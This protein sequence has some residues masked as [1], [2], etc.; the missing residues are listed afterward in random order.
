MS[1]CAN[2]KRLKEAIR[3]ITESSG[4]A[5]YWVDVLEPR[6][7]LPLLLRVYIDK[8]GGVGYAECEAV[9]RLV[10]EYLDAN[11]ERLSPL[12]DGEYF[13]EVSSPGIERPLFTPEHYMGAHGK[14]ALVFTKGRKKYEGTLLA[15]DAD[16]VTVVSDD[17]T[18]RVIAM[19]DIKKG[20]L[21]YESQ[22]GEKKGGRRQK[23]KGAPQ[24]KDK[25]NKNS[26]AV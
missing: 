17:G 3:E 12:L 8:P 11:E 7:P 16:S 1:D 19:S 25:G 10:N 15:P 24:R 18:K 14:R 2:V 26:R 6:A 23:S 20:N 5:C 22:K 9:S 13:V 21:V 4:I